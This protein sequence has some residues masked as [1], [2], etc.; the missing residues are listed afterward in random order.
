MISG[1]FCTTPSIWHLQMSL[2]N[3]HSDDSCN[4]SHTYRAADALR[5]VDRYIGRYAETQLCI[6]ELKFCRKAS[7][8]PY[9]HSPTITLVALTAFT[10]NGPHHVSQPSYVHCSYCMHSALFS[11]R[12][13]WMM[14]TQHMDE[15]RPFAGSSSPHLAV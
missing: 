12:A 13:V 11:L 15:N 10:V 9:H 14:L 6:L 2:G 4:N 7:R 3:R 1:S 8:I 5:V